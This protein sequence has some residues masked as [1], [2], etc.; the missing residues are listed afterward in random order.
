MANP[1][2]LIV[3][4]EQPFAD[5]V[6][7]VID[8]SERYRSLV[9]YSGEEALKIVKEKNGG[10]FKRDR[11]QLILLDI[12]MPGMSGIKTLE[13]IKE[14]DPDLKAVMVTAYNEDEYWYEATMSGAAVDFLI[15]P[16]TAEI[17]M[18]VLDGYFQN[19]K[20]ASK[21]IQKKYMDR[22]KMKQ[23]QEE[24][25]GYKTLLSKTEKVLED[26][27]ENLLTHLQEEMDT[28]KKR[29]DSLETGK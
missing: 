11:I 22:E 14:M 10:P 8:R 7:E 19:P 17:L 21:A 3:D 25:K 24:R 15:K 4:D 13:H 6:K 28:L 12:R 2:I 9:A 27:K 1:L 23:L 29:L 26:K 16:P 20:E 18:Q 5:T